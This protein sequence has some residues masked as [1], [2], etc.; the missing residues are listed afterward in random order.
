MQRV[1]ASR[2]EAQLGAAVDSAVARATAEDARVPRSR[3][4]PLIGVL[5]AMTLGAILLGLSWLGVLWLAGQARADLPRLPTLWSVP[6][7]LVLIGGGV[8]AGLVLGRVLE[9]SAVMVGQRWARRL[10]RRLDRNVAA[11]MDR[12]LGRPL[13]EVEAARSQLLTHLGDLRATAA[14]R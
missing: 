10:A 14:G 1:S 3:L 6:L 11:E 7:P 2:L 9:A 4:W 13:A 5:Q 12:E 8:V